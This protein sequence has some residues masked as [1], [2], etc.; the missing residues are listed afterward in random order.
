MLTGKQRS[1]LKSIANTMDP[2][3]QVGKNGVTENFIKQVEDA[4]EARELVKIK[5]LNNSLL[6]AT[7]VAS[8]IAEEID[9]EFVQSI[10]NKFVLYKE[11]RENKKIELPN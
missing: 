2:I 10:G 1:Y 3:F 7:E 5:V 8:Q 6:D 4:L 11:S 9:A